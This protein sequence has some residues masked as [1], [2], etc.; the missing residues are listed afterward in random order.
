MKKDLNQLFNMD[1]ED[2]E[3]IKGV[4]KITVLY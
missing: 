1:T 3:M 2:K 4:E